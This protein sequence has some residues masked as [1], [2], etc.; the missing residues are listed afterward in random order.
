LKNR[1]V[2]LSGS[3]KNLVFTGTS[4]TDLLRA[5]GGLHQQAS[6]TKAAT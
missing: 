3:R 4:L 2:I 1:P 5:E 6:L